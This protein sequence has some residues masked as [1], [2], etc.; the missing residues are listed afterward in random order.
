VCFAEP[1]LTGSFSE[2]DY[3][4]L[5]SIALNLQTAFEAL[6]KAIVEARKEIKDRIVRAAS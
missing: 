3:A 4:Y 2:A 5:Y 6:S 1:G